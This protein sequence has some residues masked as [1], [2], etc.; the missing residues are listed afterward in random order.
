MSWQD[1]RFVVWR[2]GQAGK[3]SFQVMGISELPTARGI[4]GRAAAR[5]YRGCRGLF[6]KKI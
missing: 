4:M 5:P 2:G 1:R 3:Q 6:S